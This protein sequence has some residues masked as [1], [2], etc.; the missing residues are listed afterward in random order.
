M[1]AMQGAA[2]ASQRVGRADVGV[3]AIARARAVSARASRDGG[4]ALLS[5][6]EHA[7]AAKR[8][9]IDVGVGIGAWRTT[10]VIGAD[11]RERR[12]PALS[13][14][15]PA[16]DELVVGARVGVVAIRRGDA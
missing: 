9:T 3:V 10:P 5:R 15:G 11:E 7:I 1:G 12:M 2:A 6:L 16:R 8:D 13:L 14:T 4:V